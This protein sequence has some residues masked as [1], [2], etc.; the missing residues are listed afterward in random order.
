MCV[1]SRDT[2]DDAFLAL[3]VLYGISRTRRGVA[4]QWQESLDNLERRDVR[5]VEVLEIVALELD[6]FQRSEGGKVRETKKRYNGMNE[7]MGRGGSMRIAMNI[8]RESVRQ[9]RGQ[10]AKEDWNRSWL[11]WC[12]RRS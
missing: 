6:V 9:G 4:H 2:Y 10:G 3:S 12:E 8:D 7:W 5:R 1:G 11:S